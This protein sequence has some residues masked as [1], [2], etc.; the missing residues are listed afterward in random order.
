MIARIICANILHM[1]ML[2]EFAKALRSIKYV[3]NHSY[4]FQHW[5][6]AFIA[7][8][9]QASAVIITEIVCMLVVI[10]STDPEGTVFNFVALN[11]ITQF[12]DFSFDSIQEEPL[13]GLSEAELGVLKIDRTTSTYCS[14][15]L[16]TDAFDKNGN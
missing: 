1:S 7:G 2:P 14:E 15:E 9:C 12:D 16:M 13:K 8:L 10:T 3:C 4:R 6:I 5:Q 11:V